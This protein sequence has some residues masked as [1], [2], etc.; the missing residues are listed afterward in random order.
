M[1]EA[2]QIQIFYGMLKGVYYSHLTG[3]KSTFS[4]MIMAGKQ[5]DLGIKLGRI[6]GPDKRKEGESSRRTTVVESF[7]DGKKG[8]EA[9]VNAVNPGRQGVHPASNAI[10]AADLLLGLAADPMALCPSSS[11]DTTKSPVGF[12]SSSVD[13]AGPRLIGSAGVSTQF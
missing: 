11:S 1:C 3:H 12:K 6:E 4:E 2:Q 7:A 5:V 9:F 8:K 13:A 10:L